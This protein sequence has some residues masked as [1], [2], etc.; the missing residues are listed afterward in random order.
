MTELLTAPASADEDVAAPRHPPVESPLLPP[1]GATAG[2]VVGQVRRVGRSPAAL[3]I[4][5]ES[6]L[7]LIVALSWLFWSSRFY[8]AT[9]QFPG[10][11]LLTVAYSL[12]GLVLLAVALG[13]RTPA[14]LRRTD[15]VLMGGALAGLLLWVV[16]LVHT[17][18]E[19]ATDEAAF[20]QGAA[21]L[22]LHGH[23]PYGADL[24]NYLQVYGVSPSSWTATLAG[25]YIHDLGYPSLSFLFTVPLLA[26]GV[27][28]Q[29][30]IWVNAAFFCLGALLLWRRLPPHLR[31]IVPLVLALDAYGSAVSGGLIFGLA[32]PFAV[33]AVAEWDRFGV[34]GERAMVR[35]GGPVFLG[36]ACAVRQDL[37][38][39]VPF[40]AVGVAQEARTTGSAPW[41]RAVRYL[42]LVATAFLLPNL[43]FIVWNPVAW[44]RG[45]IAPVISG[46]VPLGQGVIGLSLYLRIGGG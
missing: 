27:M 12:G 17:S 36:L 29:A 23:N 8:V 19:Y 39:L 25:G 26:L 33:L 18:S 37:W 15:A 44:V 9:Y 38:V 46:L 1:S 41:P 21:Q 24:S 43:P 4:S 3:G 13:A 2:Q 5:A 28:S 22:L 14:V 6:G 42:G 32:L 30:Q 34:A 11:T 16:S 20:T 45:V 10:A 31:N 7:R 40:L 35:L